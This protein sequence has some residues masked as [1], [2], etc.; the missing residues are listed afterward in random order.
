MLPGYARA[1]YEDR[2]LGHDAIRHDGGMKGSACSMTLFP[3]EQVGVFWA[4]NARP[5]NPFDGETLTGVA[6]G[7]RM[8]LFDP[9]PKV[10]MQDFISFLEID[11]NF[12]KKFFPPAPPQA[13][14]TQG[15]HWLSDAEIA[16]FAG[17]YVAT[18]SQFAS[19]VGNLQVRLIEGMTVVPGGH[20][21]AIIGG[22]PYRQIY[23]GL[24]ENPQT[25]DREAFKVTPYGTFVGPAALWIM[26]RVAW[27]DTALLVVLPLIVFPLLL[28][29]AAF[30]GFGKHPV[31]RRM[32]L[33][34]AGLGLLY[35]ICLILEGQYANWAIVADRMWVAFLWRLVLQFVLLGLL[36]WPVMLLLRWRAS[37]PA[38]SIGGI[39]AA[40]HF[41]ILALCSW[42]LVLLAGYWNLLGKF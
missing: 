26:R 15:E 8:F 30:Y 25:H 21:T 42:L 11:K 38:R 31:Y 19:F 12:V 40:S 37:P 20:N 7:I 29:L 34:A 17:T 41:V 18:H 23:A 9:K 6:K 32:G 3:A 14:R 4:V 1:F 2:E 39:A 36:I 24:F 5:Y 33:I 10:S 35:A 27:Y 16:K 28:I 13:V 22:K